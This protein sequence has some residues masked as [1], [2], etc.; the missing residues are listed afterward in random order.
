MKDNNF[1]DYL[2]SEDEAQELQRD[3][4]FSE[5]LENEWRF[6]PRPEF[7]N[8]LKNQLASRFATNAAPTPLINQIPAKAKRRWFAFPTIRR[9]QAVTLVLMLFTIAFV[10]S[11]ILVTISTSPAEVGVNTTAPVPQT[12]VETYADSPNDKNL[13][14]EEVTQ[15]LGFAPARPN[16]IPAG[17][18]LE[19]SRL[20]NDTGGNMP[21]VENAPALHLRY[22]APG[23]ASEAKVLEIHQAQ[24]VTNAVNTKYAL[25][26]IAL[27][28]SK[29]F[30]EQ[31]ILNNKGFII[32]DQ[33]WR[34]GLVTAG[35]LASRAWMDLPF[36]NGD[37]TQ[38]LPGNGKKLGQVTASRLINFYRFTGNF[39][40]SGGLIDYR[41][42]NPQQPTHTLA[43]NRDGVVIVIVSNETISNEELLKIAES[44]K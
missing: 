6:E 26:Q 40:I 9:W 25:L 33:N 21:M 20:S 8:Q 23:K 44:I 29:N 10:G 24:L 2:N 12:Q 7:Q 13:K 1:E 27:G 5:Q 32:D 34:I 11:I 37:E 43:W 31:A 17:Y 36:M 35:N 19:S 28:R 42:A 15:Q 18:K 38:K 16:Y 22:I 39:P 14:P 30:K 3:Q 41:N 4:A